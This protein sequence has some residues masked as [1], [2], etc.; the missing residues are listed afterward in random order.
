MLNIPS[1]FLVANTVYM[2]GCG[3]QSILEDLSSDSSEYMQLAMLIR[4]KRVLG[5]IVV[6]SLYF[7]L[8]NIISARDEPETA[9]HNFAQPHQTLGHSASII[10]ASDVQNAYRGNSDGLV[11]ETAIDVRRYGQPLTKLTTLEAVK[12]LLLRNETMSAKALWASSSQRHDV[13]A[14]LRQEQQLSV[15]P[16]LQHKTFAV[17]SYVSWPLALFTRKDVLQG[18]WL[19]NLKVY[20]QGV[21]SKQISIVSANQDHQ[22]M[23][24][25]WLISAITIAKLP[26]RSTLVLS[27]SVKLHEFLVSKNINSI[28]VHPTSI[29]NRA[30]SKLITTPFNQVCVINHSV[31]FY[32]KGVSD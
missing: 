20:L 14:G 15:P 2:K 16:A 4:P 5:L 17:Q 18:Q 6:L 7:L 19:Q 8:K 27:L 21:T 1:S 9:S 12:T 29:I 25:N 13:N 30:G 23:V 26:V 3:V 32:V 22:E 28:L 11:E 31:F 10:S 24:L